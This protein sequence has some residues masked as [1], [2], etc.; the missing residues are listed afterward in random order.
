MG[1]EKIAIWKWL[2][3]FGEIGYAGDATRMRPRGGWQ[4]FKKRMQFGKFI[5]TGEI[6][7]NLCL[8]R[9]IPDWRRLT[10]ARRHTDSTLFFF[11]TILIR[12]SVSINLE[13]KSPHIKPDW[14]Y[15]RQGEAPPEQWCAPFF[16]LNF[17]ASSCFFFIMVVDSTITILLNCPVSSEAQEREDLGLRWGSA[18]TGFF[19]TGSI[20]CNPTYM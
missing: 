9:S 14:I 3:H 16:C 5:N 4:R 13:W 7:Y 15:G 20:Q 10:A 8:Q 17:S 18:T 2:L 6:G 12:I 11:Y 1:V 19:H